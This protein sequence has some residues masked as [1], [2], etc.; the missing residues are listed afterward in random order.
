MEK[1]LYEAKRAHNE[2]KELLSEAREGIPL[3]KESFYE[4]DASS[5]KVSKEDSTYTI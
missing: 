5:Q 4:M 1:H 3:T 2:Y